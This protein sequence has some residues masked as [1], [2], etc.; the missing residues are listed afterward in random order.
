MDIFS[1]MV[2]KWECSNQGLHGLL[3]AKENDTIGYDGKNIFYMLE[4]RY[5]L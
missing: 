1:N 3:C 4:F 2:M 5:D